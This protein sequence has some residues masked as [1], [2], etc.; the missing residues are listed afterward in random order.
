MSINQIPS[1]SSLSAH[2]NPLLQQLLGPSFHDG[3]WCHGQKR[4][5][6][7]WGHLFWIL[8]GVRWLLTPSP[9]TAHTHTPCTVP[10]TGS[11]LRD[12]PAV[13]QARQSGWFLSRWFLFLN[14]YRLP[15]TGSA[16]SNVASWSRPG[17]AKDTV[18]IP[19]LCKQGASQAEHLDLQNVSFETCSIAWK[20]VQ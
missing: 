12:V 9:V 11:V 3:C 18:A 4:T 14:S 1:C 5:R 17:A 10:H 15:H 16:G 20:E 19:G 8:S 13:H 2:R 6:P 7:S